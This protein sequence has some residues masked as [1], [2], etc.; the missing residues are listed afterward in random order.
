MN[1]IRKRLKQIVPE[2][3]MV[4]LI[5]AVAVNMLVYCGSRMIAGGWTH[6]NIESFLDGWIPFWSPSIV[7][8]FGCYLFWAAN[9]ILISRQDK[10]EMCR[11]FSA[12]FLSRMICLA[13]F[14]LFPT[15][16][17]R[18]VVEPSGFFNKLM[19]FLYSIDAADNLFPSIH[20]LVS[21][22][23]FIGIRGKKE[24][25]V[26]YRGF[27]C[28]FALMV[29]VSTLTTKQHVIWDVI[30]GI[31]LAEFCYW[32]GKKPSV[33]GTYERLLDKVNGRIFREK[34]IN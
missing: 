7:I 1:I 21:W 11:F 8:Y 26:W 3:S 14:L 15:T 27:S 5:F 20:C 29:C 25:P 6:H 33:W 24:I 12:D 2:T 31:L 19:I 18:P 10:K 16:N 13:C 28:I 22:F 9:Y 30:G 4:P 23:C 34:G 32:L 17:T